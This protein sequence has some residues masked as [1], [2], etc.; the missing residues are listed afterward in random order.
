[1]TTTPASP[2]Q[3]PASATGWI[4]TTPSGHPHTWYQ[5]G[6]NNA[7]DSTLSMQLFE[8]DQAKRQALLSKGWAARPGNPADLYAP[9]TH[10]KRISA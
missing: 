5:H 4:I 2:N 9:N 10:G 6:W 8:P 3:P 7:I 1:M